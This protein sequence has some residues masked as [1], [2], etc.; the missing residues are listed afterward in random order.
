MKPYAIVLAAAWVLLMSVNV[1]AQDEPQPP[2][3]QAYHQLLMDLGPSIHEY[4]QSQKGTLDDI[5]AAMSVAYWHLYPDATSVSFEQQIRVYDALNVGAA[6]YVERDIWIE[7]LVE[8]WLWENSLDLSE[9]QTIQFED[10]YISVVPRDFDADGT[11]EY[12]LDVMKGGVIDRT[13]TCPRDIEAA[14]YFVVDTGDEGYRF[15]DT[16]LPWKGLPPLGRYSA[17]DGAVA[18]L[19]FDDI[20]RDGIPEWLVLEGGNTGG[21]PGMGYVDLGQLF[22]LGWRDGRLESV[23]TPY[24]NGSPPFDETTYFFTP[25]TICG[26]PMPTDVAWDFQSIDEDPALEIL[27]AQTDTDNWGCQSTETKLFDWNP[28]LQRY[29][30]LGTEETA[31]TETR[32]CAQQQAEALV[33]AGDYGGAIAEYERAL[34]A[35]EAGTLSTTEAHLY[36]QYLVARLTL[37]YLMTRQ[38][39]QAEATLDVINAQAIADEAIAS[40]IDVLTSATEAELPPI[41]IC[42]QAYN[43]FTTH[44]PAITVGFIGDDDPSIDQQTYRPE[45]IGCDAPAMI[46]EYLEQT[47]FPVD[48]APPEVLR[49]LSI[50]VADAVAFDLNED[51]I[52]EWLVWLEA[53]GVEL[54]FVPAGETYQLIYSEIDPYQRRSDLQVVQLP[55]PAGNALA[56]TKFD[57]LDVTG[58]GMSPWAYNASGIGL[59]GP[60]TQCPERNTLTG[61]LQYWRLE[62]DLLVN[63][64]AMRWCDQ[65]IDM[66]E[67]DGATEIRMNFEE[68]VYGD[69]G[70][71]YVPQEAVFVWNP[72]EMQFRKQVDQSIR[73]TTTTQAEASDRALEPSLLDV[74]NHLRDDDFEAV[75][76]MTRPEFVLYET[77]NQDRVL[78]NYYLRALSL[79]ATS[80]HEQASQLYHEL[81]TTAPDLV[82]GML[83]ELHID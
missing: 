18:E 25:S 46:R 76:A 67:L 80:Q 78:G 81:A 8:A 48:V 56:V 31:A 38:A 39:S 83:A 61:G 70:W 15:V 82:W 20:N 65:Q 9:T 55:Q 72:D 59:G 41:Q 23:L 11:D 24:R 12:L 36:E 19:G 22:I 63:V 14:V 75:L 69:E 13:Q 79:E 4:V 1:Q 62:E 35:T 60:G 10:V 44:F 32:N 66:V 45:R 58:G 64:L 16:G 21:G 49:E 73:P 50:G 68:Q 47:R 26:G 43:V 40:Y 77:D 3:A 42:T 34:S 5:L 30:Y 17:S 6:S 28:E 74:A 33:W 52:P 71:I 27:Q 37:A 57:L 53:A 54:L 7:R 29:I 51:G 2:S